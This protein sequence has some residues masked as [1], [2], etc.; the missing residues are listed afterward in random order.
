MQQTRPTGRRL[1]TQ[2]IGHDQCARAL[3]EKGANIEAVRERQNGQWTALMFAV[4]DGHDLCA[5][6]L[7]K[8]GANLEAQMNQGFTAL[9]L[10]APER[11]RSVR[12]RTD[13]GEAQMSTRKDRKMMVACQTVTICAPA[14]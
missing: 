2:Q 13:R 9:M 6:E 14:H 7:I 10:S 11:S 5:R 8:A 1:C 3:I 4:Q 12:P